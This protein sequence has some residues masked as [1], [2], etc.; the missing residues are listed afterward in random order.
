MVENIKKALDEIRPMLQRDGGDVEFVDYTD[1][2]V[3]LVR[4]QGRCAGC[5]YS[6]MTVKQGIEAY[7]KEE[8]PEVAAVEAVE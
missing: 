2:Y 4:L 3:V 6:Q 8:I 1:D 7:L 5:P